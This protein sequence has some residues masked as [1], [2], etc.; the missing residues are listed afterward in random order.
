VKVAADDPSWTRAEDDGLDRADAADLRRRLIPGAAAPNGLSVSAELV[1]SVALP[2]VIA[3]RALIAASLGFDG[4]LRVRAWYALDTHPRSLALSLPEGAR[5]IRA[6]VDGRTVEEIQADDD[7]TSFRFG[8]PPGSAGRPVLV[9]VEYQYAANAVRK[10]WEAPKLLD[11]ADVLQSLWHVQVPWNAAL[12]GVPAGWADE[13]QWYWDVYVWKRRPVAPIDRLI[14]WVSEPTSSA[15]AAADETFADR[16]DAHAYLFGRAGPPGPLGAWVVSRAWIIVACSG[17]VLALG[18]AAAF[19]GIGERRAW[20]ITAA[21][22]LLS[23]MFLHPSTIALFLQSAACG[24]VLTLLGYLIHRGVR[25]EP[26]APTTVRPGSASSGG[27]AYDSSQR[28]A[29][30]VGSDDS[31]AVRVRTSSTLDYLSPPPALGSELETT[32][33]PSSLSGNRA[34]P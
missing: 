3:S 14:A 1:K 4:D 11:G 8:L 33:R 17:L 5:W 34:N 7:G 19:T 26:P 29:L 9:E 28:S 32:S 30:G 24:A 13:N 27:S 15:P 18:L 6:R 20:G 31:T 2:R 21:A 23:A 25:R 22:G 12:V 10:P 16:D